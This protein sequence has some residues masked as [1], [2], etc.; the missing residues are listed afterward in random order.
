MHQQSCPWPPLPAGEEDRRP[1]WYAVLVAA[2]R[3]IPAP[4]RTRTV[5]T[6]RLWVAPRQTVPAIRGRI[7]FAPS[8]VSRGFPTHAEAK[9]WFAGAGYG[10]L[11]QVQ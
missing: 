10:D 2:E 5:L 3:D 6:Y 9:A 7:Q 1:D 11:P 8:A 4:R